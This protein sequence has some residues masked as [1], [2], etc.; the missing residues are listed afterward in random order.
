[1]GYLT[2]YFENDENEKRREKL[3]DITRLRKFAEF[4]NR[5]T[6]L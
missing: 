1:M 4:S 6:V 2:S 5:N 3:L